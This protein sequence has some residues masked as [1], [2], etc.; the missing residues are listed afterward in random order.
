[1]NISITINIELKVI[2]NE[3][4][5][6]QLSQYH[7]MFLNMLLICINQYPNHDI[8]LLESSFTGK[9]AS[10]NRSW[11]SKSEQPRH[12]LCVGDGRN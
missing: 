11:Q 10:L 8:N 7:S 12:V 1:M 5:N 4:L 3:N 6:N 2:L 9:L